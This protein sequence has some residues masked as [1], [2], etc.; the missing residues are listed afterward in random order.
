MELLTSDTF[1]CAI[2]SGMYQ[3][4]VTYEGML[5]DGSPYTFC[6]FDPS[7]VR[8]CPVDPVACNELVEFTG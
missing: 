3:I 4:L 7:A 5:V 2:V 6:V 8:V 1:V